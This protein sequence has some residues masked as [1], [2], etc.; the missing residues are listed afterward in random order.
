M[1]LFLG[2]DNMTQV[3]IYE[4]ENGNVSVC[5]PTGELSVEH[6]LTRDCPEGAIIIDADNL[7]QGEDDFFDAWRLVD[8]IV[9]VDL[10]AAKTIAMNRF[11]LLAAEEAGKR[12]QNTS[13]GIDNAVSDADF[14]ANLTAKRAA[15]ASA[16]STAE[17]RQIVV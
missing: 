15:I 7:P 5:I 17:L 4:N 2:T 12:N 6:V 14:I 3:I 16:T 13:I 8:E 11:N 10:I 9:S 1:S